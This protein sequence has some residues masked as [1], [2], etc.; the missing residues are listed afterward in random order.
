MLAAYRFIV[1]A[2]DS[3]WWQR[4]VEN[5]SLEEEGQVLEMETHQC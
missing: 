1:S 2:S 3:G 4:F 5:L